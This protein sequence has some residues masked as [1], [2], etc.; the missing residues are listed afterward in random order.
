MKRTLWTLLLVCITTACSGGEEPA[1]PTREPQRNEGTASASSVAPT[2]IREPS[3]QMPSRASAD[4]TRTR[5]QPSSQPTSREGTPVTFAL[6]WPGG[7]RGHVDSR[8]EVSGAG[9]AS[10]SAQWAFSIRRDGARSIIDTRDLNVEISPGPLDEDRLNSLLVTLSIWPSMSM[11]A[12]GQLSL[13]DGEST[14]NEIRRALFGEL[15]PQLRDLA[16]QSPAGV[17]FDTS[18]ESLLRLAQSHTATITSLEGDTFTPGQPRTARTSATSAI[19]IELEQDVVTELT[20]IGPCFE[21]DEGARCAWITMR[22]T[23]DVTPLQ[24][25]A[26]LAQQPLTIGSLINEARVIVE[27]ATL[28]PHRIVLEKTT[29]MVVHEGTEDHPVESREVS[30]W[31]FHYEPTT[32]RP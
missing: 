7:A 3:A 12:Q 5:T 24:E 20:G 9:N 8:R 21:G 16:A 4:I 11:D 28:L 30:S 22:A 29:T 2:R 32:I 10:G 1:S 17:L 23:A 31:I 26:E 25:A 15:T 19:G 6:L 13:R 14:R 27:F 18:D